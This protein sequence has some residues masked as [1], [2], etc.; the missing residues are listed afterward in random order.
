MPLQA[1]HQDNTE[2][3]YNWALWRSWQTWTPRCRTQSSCWGSGWCCGA[4]AGASGAALRTSARTGWRPCQACVLLH[5]LLCISMPPQVLAASHHPAFPHPLL[6]RH[7][8][9][10]EYQRGHG[11]E[12]IVTVHHVSGVAACRGAH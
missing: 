1:V 12:W 5:M 7:A 3:A 11:K 9:I 2:E 6:A 4:M 8:E 10:V